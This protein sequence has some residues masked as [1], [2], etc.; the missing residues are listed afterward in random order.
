M[1]VLRHMVVQ[2]EE[3]QKG[4]LVNVHYAQGGVDMSKLM[5]GAGVTELMREENNWTKRN[6]PREKIMAQIPLTA[7]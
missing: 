5:T 4:V 6:S 1:S 2:A 3:K 7:K